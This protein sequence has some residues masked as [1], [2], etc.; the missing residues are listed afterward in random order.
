MPATWFE[1]ELTKKIVKDLKFEFN[2]ELRVLEDFKMDSYI[3]EGGLSYKVHKYLSVST[4][5]RFE[6]EWDYRK[7]NGAY[8]GKNSFNRLA[9]DLKSGYE[10][11]RFNIQGRIRYTK[12]LDSLNNASE[13]RYRAKVDY[14]I[15]GIKLLPFLSIEFFNDKSVTELEKTSISGGFKDID[16]V[17]YTGGMAYDINKNNSVSLFYRLQNNRVKNE[18]NNILGLSY[19]H[20]F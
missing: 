16:K 17:R 4:F 6:E 18:W 7:K 9:F 12:G 15:K 2:S 1:L 14:D 5:Y 8:Q 19:S 3:F 13:M 10:I 11:S 20:N